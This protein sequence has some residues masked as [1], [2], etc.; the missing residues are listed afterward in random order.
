MI[1][2]E[3]P[4]K[5]TQ[6]GKPIGSINQA[7]RNFPFSTPLISIP[8]IFPIFQGFPYFS[9]SG[10]QQASW[11]ALG[12]QYILKLGPSFIGACFPFRTYARETLLS[13]SS[14]RFRRGA[15]P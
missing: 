4:F 7:R 2:F 3:V 11:K 13:H 10:A 8:L 9:Y 5:Q 14:N 1:R 6:P 15:T 12:I